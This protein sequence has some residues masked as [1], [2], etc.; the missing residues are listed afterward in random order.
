[1][2][3]YR[4]GKPT[5]RSEI[6]LEI[7]THEQAK[8]FCKRFGYQWSAFINECIERRLNNKSKFAKGSDNVRKPKDA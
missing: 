3:H 4:N 7:S 2:S 5:T 8:Q 1:M 6:F